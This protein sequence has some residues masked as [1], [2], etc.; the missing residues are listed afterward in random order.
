[1]GEKKKKIKTNRCKKRIN[2]VSSK[3]LLLIKANQ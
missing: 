2:E 3:Q 1:V